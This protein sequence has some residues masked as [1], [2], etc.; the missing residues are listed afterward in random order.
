MVPS[1]TPSPIVEYGANLSH[2]CMLTIAP[3]RFSVEPALK[4]RDRCR[5]AQ[6]LPRPPYS[7][8]PAREEKYFRQQNP[9]GYHV[10]RAVINWFT[11][12]PHASGDKYELKVIL[13]VHGIIARYSAHTRQRC[14]GGNS[15]SVETI[16]GPSTSPKSIMKTDRS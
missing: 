2:C 8:L 10:H 6:I 7:C 13:L 11:S 1:S 9:T 12:L 16:S 14:P 4:R 15:N 5:Y 3:R